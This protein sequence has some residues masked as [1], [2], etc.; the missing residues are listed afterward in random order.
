MERVAKTWLVLFVLFVCFLNSFWYSY[1]RTEWTLPSTPRE[2]WQTERERF[3]STLL[4]EYWRMTNLVDRHDFRFVLNHE[5]CER[6]VEVF[7]L[8][9]VH[10]APSHW[11]RRD[12]IRRTWGCEDNDVGG[13]LRV[14]FLLGEVSDALDQADIEKESRRHGDVV[15]GNFLD[16]Y[17]NLT[18]KH[19]MGLKWVA[20]FCRRAKYVL[21]TDDDTFVD[22]FV[23]VD[24]LEHRFG[25][26]P[27]RNLMAC[28]VNRN[29]YVKRSH[30]SKW[31][32]PVR[33]YGPDYYP[34]Y[35]AGWSIVMSADVVYDL[36]I[37]SANF[38]YFWI[39]DVAISGILAQRIGIEH[40]G[41]D[42]DVSFR[43]MPLRAWFSSFA[44]QWPPV[45]GLPDV[46]VAT[47]YRLWNETVH[48]HYSSIK[49]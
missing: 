20:H 19:V 9:F 44:T 15:Q 3:N 17:K 42:P 39:D 12:A 25:A 41:L 47:V 8:I 29:A 31:F 2:R 24:F 4:D 32:V 26:S 10:S 36:Y 28:F 40:V 13:T 14:I 16:S 35:C 7:L 38:T 45:F 43:W 11:D 30:R 48:R 49:R 21:K 27:P 1:T 5:R 6:D 34:P 33:D 22:I 23:V 46:D 18:Y 37:E